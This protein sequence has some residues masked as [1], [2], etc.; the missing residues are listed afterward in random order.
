ML[1]CPRPLFPPTKSEST[2]RG[3]RLRNEDDRDGLV[4]RRAVAV[5][6]GAE[7]DDELD[8][9][10]A[11]A[12]LARALHR[13]RHRRR[14]GAGAEPARRGAR[15]SGVPHSGRSRRQEAVAGGGR[16][17][18]WLQYTSAVSYG[19]G[20]ACGAALSARRRLPRTRTRTRTA[21]GASLEAEADTLACHRQGA[22]AQYKSGTGAAPGAHPMANAGMKALTT[23]KG[24]SRDRSSSVSGS[25]MNACTPKPHSTVATY[26]LSD[27]SSWMTLQ[28][29]GGPGRASAAGALHGTRPAPDPA[30]SPRQRQP[31]IA[32]RPTPVVLSQNRAQAGGAPAGWSR[33]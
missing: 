26:R 13:H 16:A 30:H 1:R 14:R 25:E 24:L 6:V 18:R 15:P 21:A 22:D 5:D 2:P 28:A 20:T 23:D 29:C 31:P 8:Q 10:L 27:L 12:Q 17:C 4:E 32:R 9:T 19:Q 33:K 7:R 11:A 3:A